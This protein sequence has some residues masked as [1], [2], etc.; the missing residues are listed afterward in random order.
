MV[1]PEAGQW[2]PSGQQPGGVT[3]ASIQVGVELSH[4]LIKQ[5]ADLLAVEAAAG[6]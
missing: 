6:R 4:V 1:P 2:Q 5:A 3:E